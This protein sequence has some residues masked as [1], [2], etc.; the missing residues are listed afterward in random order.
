MDINA[1][2][3]DA[4]QS[5]LGSLEQHVYEQATMNNLVDTALKALVEAAVERVQ[6]SVPMAGGVASVLMGFLK[7]LVN[8]ADEFGLDDKIIELAS[9]HGLDSALRDRVIS[10]LTRYLQDNGGRLMRVAL[11]ALVKKVSQG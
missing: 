7:P 5:V 4:K 6:V 10:G 9:S 11:D 3:A 8:A 2:I 1:W